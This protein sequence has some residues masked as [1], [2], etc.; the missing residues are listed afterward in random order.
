MKQKAF[1][2]L[3]A[4]ALIICT[5]PQ[6]AGAEAISPAVLSVPD[7]LSG[8]ISYNVPAWSNA[9]QWATA[10]LQKA[11][12]A[13]LIPD[14]LNGADLTRPI[15]REEFAELAVKLYEKSTGK[16][17]L[18]VSPNPFPD[19][20][21]LEVLKAYQLGLTTGIPTEEGLI[22]SPYALINREQCA[23]M[24]YRTLKAIAPEDNY[25]IA[26]IKDF[27]DQKHISGWAV[28]GTK[29]LAK[30]GII[31][32]DNNG[33]FMPRPLTPEQ[34][35]SGYG[36]AT[37]EAAV[38]MSVRSFEQISP[39]A[40]GTAAGDNA[41]S[42]GSITPPEQQNPSNEAP[43]QVTGAFGNDLIGEWSRGGAFSAEYFSSDI[44]VGTMSLVNGEYY[45]FNA[46]GTFRYIISVLGGTVGFIRYESQIVYDSGKYKV[47]GNYIIFY[48]C[49]QTYYKGT[50]LVLVHRDKKI[51]DPDK[52]EIEEFDPAGKRF[53][54]MMGWFEKKN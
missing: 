25:D 12:E 19:T 14:I 49:V 11:D 10:E 20:N 54:T 2:L 41:S 43:A 45:Q 47:D 3:L 27:P 42:S 8:V 9:S 22:F 51:D 32:G 28:E 23:T 15:T 29:Y 48:D 18:P 1:V 33:N 24:L 6:Y 53:K 34:E 16:A 36:M 38:L 30:L 44:S 4:A 13:G 40:L 37:R 50:P 21:N 46:D 39:S 17:A 26:G 35:A 52:V 31:K 5:I 7:P